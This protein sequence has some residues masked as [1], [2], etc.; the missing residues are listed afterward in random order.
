MILKAWI[1]AFRLRTLPLSLACIGMGSFLAAAAGAFRWDVFVLCLIT[2]VFLQLLSNLANDYGDSVHGADHAQRTGPMRAV[3]S[4]LITAAQMRAAV[5]LFT[6]LCLASGIPLLLVALGLNMLAFLFFLAVGLLSIA[7]AIAYTNGRRPYGYAGFGDLAVFIFFG[8]VG[9]FGSCY[10][11]T[12]QLSLRFLLPAFSCGFFSIGVLNV[13]NIRDIESDRAA[14]KFS[15]PVRVGRERAIV[16]HWILLT[17]GWLSAALYAALVF[18]H[19]MQFLFLL[20]LPLFVFNGLA[21]TRR[22]SSKLD[23]MLR[24]LA[25][26]TLLFVVLFGVG[27]VIG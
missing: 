23:P 8:V 5:I 4:G 13:N 16:Y 9:V 14:G 11:F 26:S 17:A 7:A 22:P 24:Q 18:R 15:I 19:P 12:H 2:T 1:S 20:S 6:V 3:Q 10:L 27:M 21:V 25:I